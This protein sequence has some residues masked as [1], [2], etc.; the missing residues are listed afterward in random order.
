MGDTTKKERLEAVAAEV[1]A[2]RRCSLHE[3][4]KNP[5]VGG[6]DLDSP[7]VLVGEAPGRKEDEL[8]KP[9]VGSAGKIL[10]S[11]LE[12]AG[13]ERSRLFITNVVK[14]HPPKNRRPL[15]KEVRACTE[16]LEALL[17]IISP[18]VIAPMG[19]SST[20]YVLGRYGL[21]RS[22]IGEVHGRSLEAQAPWGRIVIFPLYHPAAVLYNR[23]LE[24]EL[25]RDFASLKRVLEE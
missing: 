18:R 1:L 7:L 8:G 6:G 23:S 14:C 20:S 24:G 4:R 25:K 15:S 12:G 10:D 17:G 13:L 9:F 2:C 21:E 16:H 19:N 22:S 5:V 3:G 11:M